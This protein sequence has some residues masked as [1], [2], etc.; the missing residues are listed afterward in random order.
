M[1]RRLAL[2]LVFTTALTL[3]LFSQSSDSQNKKIDIRSPVG[4]MHIGED[5][6]AKKVGVPLY[7]GARPKAG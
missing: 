2:S 4:D 6:D 7:P 3:P 1:F 5:A